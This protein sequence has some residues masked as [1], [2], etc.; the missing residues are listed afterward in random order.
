[1]GCRLV[2]RPAES[3]HYDVAATAGLPL[4]GEFRESL[5]LVAQETASD[6]DEKRGLAVLLLDVAVG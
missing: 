1:L 3:R 4:S 6:E 2:N 5:D